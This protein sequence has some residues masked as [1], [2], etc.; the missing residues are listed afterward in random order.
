MGSPTTR[1]ISIVH[2]F[3]EQTNYELGRGKV[4]KRKPM[5]VISSPLAH[6][7]IYILDESDTIDFL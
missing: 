2:E 3:F 6:L 5:N 7:E 1:A 4:N